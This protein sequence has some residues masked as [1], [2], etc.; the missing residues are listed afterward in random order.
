MAVE[1]LG[2]WKDP[3]THHGSRYWY[4][5]RSREETKKEAAPGLP[6]GESEVIPQLI[7]NIK[8]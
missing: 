7:T 5:F 6:V 8:T 4:L 3:R 1:I 2:R